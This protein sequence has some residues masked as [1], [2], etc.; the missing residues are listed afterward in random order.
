MFMEM[1]FVDKQAVYSSMPLGRIQDTIEQHGVSRPTWNEVDPDKP[2]S[3]S[4]TPGLPDVYRLIPVENRDGLF[5]PM[6]HDFQ[7]WV[8]RMNIDRILSERL[9]DA[10]FDDFYRLELAGY[11]DRLFDRALS[12]DEL[13]ALLYKDK[14][15]TTGK[16]IA[17][18]RSLFATDRSHNNYTGLDTCTNYVAQENFDGGL[19]KFSN[20][21]TGRWVGQLRSWNSIQMQVINA[22][23]GFEQYHWMTH[24]W[25]FDEPLITARE[26][27]GDTIVIARDGIRRQYGHFNN[28]VVLPVILPF[29]DWAVVQDGKVTQSD[30][31]PLEK[32]T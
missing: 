16:T 11:E 6:T 12:G 5:T 28:R 26:F 13:A 31:L 25:L 18:F 30:A 24:P 9:T 29:D 10:E 21:V 14:Y 27:V 4:R 23:K 2:K 19:A 17:D 8:Y 22:S 3:P 1:S 20:V 15:S 7:F 32:F